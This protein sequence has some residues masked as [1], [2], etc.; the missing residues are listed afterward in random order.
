MR[1]G[2]SVASAQRADPAPLHLATQPLSNPH[3][4]EALRSPAVPFKGP[5]V[6]SARLNGDAYEQVLDAAGPVV[7]V[8]G[9]KVRLLRVASTTP[10]S[11][12]DT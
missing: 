7:I 11:R 9:G 10:A 2:P 1:R 6:H 5:M 12:T 3:T 8:G 4:P